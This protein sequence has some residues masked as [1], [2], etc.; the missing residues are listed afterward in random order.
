MNLTPD[1]V[2]ISRTVVM[3][4]VCFSLAKAQLI[5]MSLFSCYSTQLSPGTEEIRLVFLDLT[6][7]FV[8]DVQ[9]RPQCAW[10]LGAWGEVVGN[11]RGCNGLDNVLLSVTGPS[12][13]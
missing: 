1:S 8:V 11:F 13:D 7:Q 10:C 12:N 9:G 3:F 5:C 6:V 2:T 4:W